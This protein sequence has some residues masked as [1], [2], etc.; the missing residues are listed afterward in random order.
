VAV[1]PRAAFYLDAYLLAT[2]AADSDDAPLF[3]PIVA[4]G[5]KVPILATR[6]DVMRAIRRR[7]REAGFTH[8]ISAHLLR[9]TGLSLMLNEGVSWEE[10]KAIAGFHHDHHLARYAGALASAG[11]RAPRP[12]HGVDLSRNRLIES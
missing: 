11:L 12:G 2:G 7:F 5:E 9:A 1:H 10:A 4:P 6:K 8:G 3:R